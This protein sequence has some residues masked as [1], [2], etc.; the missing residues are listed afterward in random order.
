MNSKS[1]LA[2]LALAAVATANAQ[3]FTESGDAGNSLATAVTPTSSNGNL[4][5]ING[6]NPITSAAARCGPDH[7]S[8][9]A[10]L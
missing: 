2:G 10:R 3:T 8:V 5:T 4:T 1:L 9:P 6:F 7:S